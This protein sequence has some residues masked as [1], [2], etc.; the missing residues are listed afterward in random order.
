MAPDFKCGPTAAHADNSGEKSG[1]RASVTGDIKADRI[2]RLA[3]LDCKRQP[4]IAKPNNTDGLL[5]Q[6][7]PL[8][9]MK[10]TVW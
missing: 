8:K 1:N 3:E 10:L 7:A 2:K 6:D 9:K 4:D 5:L